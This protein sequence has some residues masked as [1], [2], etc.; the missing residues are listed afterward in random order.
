MSFIRIVRPRQLPQHHTSGR[1]AK[2]D[3][4]GSLN[5]ASPATTNSPLDR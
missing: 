4:G 2:A 1:E 3:D 5:T